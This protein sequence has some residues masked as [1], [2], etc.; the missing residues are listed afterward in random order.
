[1][2]IVKEADV[3]KNE[4]L[5][6]AAVLF[7]EKGADKTSVADI[8]EAVGIAKGTLYHRFKSKES[9]MDALMHQKTKRVVFRGVPP[10][11]AGIVRDGVAEGL[12]A[13]PLLKSLNILDN[14]ILP[15]T[16]EHHRNVKQLVQKARLLM[17]RMGIADLEQR[18][19]TQA[20]GG[21][22][23][24]AGICRALMSDPEIL[25]GDE[26][27]GALNSAAARDVM[28]LLSQINAGGTA[29]LLITHDAG[30]AARADRVLFLQDGKI[31]R[32]TKLG[33]FS[34][35]ELGRRTSEIAG[36]MRGMGI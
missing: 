23:Q 8:M 7:A 9:I 32:E 2:R 31:V 36:Q 15:Q 12:F 4:I 34:E 22:L 5:D 26:P 13:P 3:R 14:T 1:M 6:A 24:R 29:I 21:Q 11:M 19:I 30:V 18:E 10:I 28:D 27:T 33:K 16:R 17:K 25:F 20:S 35:A